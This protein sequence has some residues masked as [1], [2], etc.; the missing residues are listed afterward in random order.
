MQ[1]SEKMKLLCALPTQ[2]GLQKPFGSSPMPIS[3]SSG[4]L[5]Q[6]AL[7]C[8]GQAWSPSERMELVQGAT[9]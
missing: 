5:P 1:T 4:L 8:L 9:M 2:A 6:T 3:S 7:L